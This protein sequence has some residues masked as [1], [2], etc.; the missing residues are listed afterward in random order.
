MEHDLH[1]GGAITIPGELTGPLPRKVSS[2]KAGVNSGMFAACVVI[3]ALAG[4][5]GFSINAVHQF[6]NLAALRRDGTGATAQISGFSHT[7][8]KGGILVVIYSFTANGMSFTG[9]ASV[10]KNMERSVHEAS[11]LSIRYLPTNPAVN[12]PSAW[13]Q[14][15]ISTWLLLLLPLFPSTIGILILL[16]DRRDRRLLAQGIPAIATITR[17]Y[18]NRKTGY[19]ATYEFRAR[20]G[21]VQTGSD[22]FDGPQEIGA[23]LCV[24]YLPQ[25]PKRNL[26]YPIQDYR[27]DQ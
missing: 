20:D 24:I 25:Y 13:E 16:S 19:G 21:K 7:G 12:Q 2:S 6:Q 17:S 5:F 18:F 1:S 8:K 9:E 11:A 22:T 4:S 10:P 15:T 23:S 3:L 14:S 26:P 27:V